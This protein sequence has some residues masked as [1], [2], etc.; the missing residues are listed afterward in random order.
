MLDVGL[1]TA[2]DFSFR[3]WK[4]QYFSLLVWQTHS[5]CHDLKFWSNCIIQQSIYGQ[6]LLYTTTINLRIPW[7]INPVYFI[8][9]IILYHF[10]SLVFPFMGSVCSMHKYKLKS[11]HSH[12]KLDRFLAYVWLVNFARKNLPPTI[13]P[14]TY[15]CHLG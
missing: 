5:R 12:T 15:H 3:L 1:C 6:E 2:C 4:G 8:P 9:S 10:I 11:N 7:V 13:T 14:P